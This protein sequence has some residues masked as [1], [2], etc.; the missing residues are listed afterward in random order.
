MQSD[1]AGLRWLHNKDGTLALPLSITWGEGTNTKT[2]YSIGLVSGA[3]DQ[4]RPTLVPCKGNVFEVPMWKFYIGSKFGVSVL[5]SGVGWAQPCYSGL[6]D[7][8]RMTVIQSVVSDDAKELVRRW[9]ADDCDWDN[10]DFVLAVITEDPV[11][12]CKA[13]EALKAD[14]DVVC[15]AV[16]QQGTLLSHA[17]E[18]LRGDRDVVRAAVSQ[19]GMALEYASESLQADKDIVLAALDR[20]FLPNRSAMEFASEELQG[21]KDM[22][23][24]AVARAGLDLR[25]LSEELQADKDV[26]LAAKKSPWKSK[27]KK[28]SKCVIS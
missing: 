7:D 27:D 23:I 13:S 18:E 14:R 6:L 17:S 15:A 26:V 24:A 10:K 16:T 11:G 28:E 5:Q 20:C 19:D 8:P 25:W 12:L 9:R 3:L 22:V 2:E 4:R 21:D 1:K